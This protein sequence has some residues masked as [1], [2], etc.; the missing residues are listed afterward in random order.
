MGKN[1]DIKLHEFTIGLNGKT[2]IMFDK[3]CGDMK[4]KPQ[5][6]EKLYLTSNM[7]L[8]LPNANV[9]SFLCAINTDSVI[10]RI[11]GK[12]YKEMCQAVLSYTSVNPDEILI[13]RKGKPVIFTGLSTTEGLSV[14]DGVPR[15]PKGIPNPTKRPVLAL[16]WEMEFNISILDNE[17]F[18]ESDILRLFKIGGIMVGLGTFRGVHGKFEITKWEEH[19]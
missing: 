15:L 19:K 3:F 11:Y 1:G 5:P 13:T 4:S 6:E 16:P 10:K 9:M 18:K 12:K 7:E 8:M 17:S 14:A 2:S